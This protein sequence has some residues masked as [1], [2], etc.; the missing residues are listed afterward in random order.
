[1]RG[2]LFGDLLQSARKAMQQPLHCVAQV[3]DQVETIGH[4]EGFG[5]AIRSGLG[6][7]TSAVAAEDLHAGV[8]VQPGGDGLGVAVRQEIDGAVALPIDEDG[9]VCLA[10]AER[11]VIEAEDARG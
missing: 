7:G 6:I 11:E 4:L 10:F 5:G 9:A 8:L 1:V 2:E 3:L